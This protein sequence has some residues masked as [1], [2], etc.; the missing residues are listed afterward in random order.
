M[1][2]RSASA[3][4]LRRATRAAT[5]G[6]LLVAATGAGTVAIDALHGADA[7]AA[8]ARA[9]GLRAAATGAI[10]LSNSRAGQ[11][12]VSSGA[13]VPGT[14][15]TGTISIGNDG[16]ASAG[17]SLARG[18]VT[19][20]PGPHGGRLSDALDLRVEELA[21]T[22]APALVYVGRLAGLPDVSLGSFS[23]GS[24]R[25]YRFTVT[26]PDGGVPSSPTTGDNAYQGSS[27]SVDY[28]WIGLAADDSDADSPALALADSELGL[29]LTRRLLGDGLRVQFTCPAA[30]TVDSQLLVG[31]GTA[32]KLGLRVP[33][34]T[35]A[36]LDLAKYST[37]GNASM[38]LPNGGKRTL[39]IKLDPGAKAAMR[40]ARRPV[41]LVLR[42]E[43]RTMQGELQRTLVKPIVIRPAALDAAADPAPIPVAQPSSDTRPSTGATGRKGEGAPRADR[44][45][46]PPLTP[47]A[48]V[49]ADGGST[50]IIGAVPHAASAAWDAPRGRALVLVTALLAAG[51][52][53]LT[54]R[55]RRRDGGRPAR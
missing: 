24:A 47:P 26:M 16:K 38:R 27:V 49:G 36:A 35:A 11:A 51:G 23:P 3:Q 34:A 21:A 7:S 8:A 14:S 31:R 55:R 18:V 6:A 1:D 30:C 10:R 44:T 45:G 15:T 33:L 32:R 25:T 13:L 2:G 29:A 20:R 22:G 9:P 4:W 43:L 19:D 39:T 37:V 12:I 40:R 41:H 48:A 50:G 42:S 5:R 28:R 52:L 53:L 46:A 17:V 54:V